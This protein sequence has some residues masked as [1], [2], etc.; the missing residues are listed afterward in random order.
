[1]NRA[2]GATAGAYLFVAARVAGGRRFGVRSAENQRRLADAL[3]RDQLLLLNAWRLPAWLGRTPGPLPLRDQTVVNTQLAQLLARGV[4]LV[5]ALDVVASTVTASARPT[6]DR[7][8][9]Q[10][11]AGASFADACAATG[12]FDAVTTAVY[13]SAER[14]GDLGGATRELATTMRRQLAIRSRAATLMMYPAV[15][16]T[17]ALVI[18]AVM[19]MFIVPM[20]ADNLAALGVTFPWYTRW[21]AA[22]GAFGRAHLLWVLA[23]V[24][25][26]VVIAVVARRPLV[27]RAALIVRRLPVVRDL[28]LAQEAARFFSVMAAM[29]RSGVPLADALAVADQAVSHAR[30]RTQLESLRRRLVE[31]GVLR[32]L[33]DSVT[34][35]PLATRR[36]LIAAERAGNLETA[37]DALAQDMVDEVERRSTRLLAVL[38]PFL[39]IL[40]FVL[41]GSMLLS[42]MIPLMTSVRQAI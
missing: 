30:L 10:V 11:A 41:I 21:V 26:A 14:T 20:V 8:R 25:A 33:I 4:P 3:R 16:L 22:A 9:E 6:I 34:A 2:R 39:I 42:I 18:G 28:V 36:L 32:Q 5:E 17:V 37:F 29:T 19:L 38:E 27:R 15:V 24:A 7:I 12:A 23:A 40:M 31:G 1:M 13:R 35:L